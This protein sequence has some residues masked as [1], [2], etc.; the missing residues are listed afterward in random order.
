MPELGSVT[1][2]RVGSDTTGNIWLGPRAR[3]ARRGATSWA[4]FESD[5]DILERYS[6]LSV[7]TQL[8]DT[9]RG[10]LKVQAAA[11]VPC[12]YEEVHAL[13]QHMAALD[14]IETTYR[15]VDPPF[16]GRGAGPN[17]ARYRF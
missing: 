17:A 3:Q 13:A 15:V 11:R 16:M 6:D 4:S 14:A 7:R 5:N 1:A 2:Y 12:L 8:C 9:A 10:L